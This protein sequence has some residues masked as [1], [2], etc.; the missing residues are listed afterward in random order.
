M[1][2]K[3]GHLLP[4]SLLAH[5]RFPFI[6]LEGYLVLILQQLTE[7]ELAELP[8][9]CWE[10]G[11]PVCVQELKCIVWRAGSVAVPMVRAACS[12]ELCGALGA[13]PS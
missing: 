6:M 3:V 8:F 9:C 7:K 11:S 1:V 10:K 13:E 12:E 4:K 5:I 2:A